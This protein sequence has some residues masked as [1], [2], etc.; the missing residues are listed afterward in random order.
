MAIAENIGRMTVRYNDE[1]PHEVVVPNEVAP[2]VALSHDMFK[3][4][5]DN[6]VTINRMVVYF[7]RQLQTVM[8]RPITQGEDP[9][10]DD[11]ET[12]SDP[13]GSAHQPLAEHEQQDEEALEDGLEEDTQMAEGDAEAATEPDMPY[14]GSV[15]RKG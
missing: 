9:R 13:D 3:F 11:T 6:M 14:S 4:M 1:Q 7:D 2:I 10:Q 8:S 12:S 5:S 15:E